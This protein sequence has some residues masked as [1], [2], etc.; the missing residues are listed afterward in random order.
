MPKRDVTA[1]EMLCTFIKR[2]VLVEPLWSELELNLTSCGRGEE[3]V[4][5]MEEVVATQMTGRLVTAGVCI[6]DALGGRGGVDDLAFR[7]RLQRLINETMNANLSRLISARLFDLVTR[8]IMATY[9]WPS[10]LASGE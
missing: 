3:W 9:E 8:S 4:A 7:Q 1:G 10:H 2:N 6:A 5:F